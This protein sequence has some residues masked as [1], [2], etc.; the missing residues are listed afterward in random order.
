MSSFLICTKCG[1]TL[2]AKKLK[3]IDL[4]HEK[5][6]K[7]GN[8]N[9]NSDIFKKLNITYIC[10]KSVITSAQLDEGCKEFYNRIGYYI[11]KK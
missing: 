3:F 11:K 8:L 2:S 1:R 6:E 4:V 5:I 10:C 9:D 7:G